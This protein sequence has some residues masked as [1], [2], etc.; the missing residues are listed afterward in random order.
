MCRLWMLMA[1]GV[2]TPA[3]SL[4]VYDRLHFARRSQVQQAA[5]ERSRF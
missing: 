4:K 1:G 2:V 5:N 3:A